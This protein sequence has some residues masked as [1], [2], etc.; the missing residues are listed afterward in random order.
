[1]EIRE[2]FLVLGLE[3]TKDAGQIKKA[4]RARLSVTNPEDDPEGFKRLRAAYE[5]AIAYTEQSDEEPEAEAADE[6]PSGLWVQRAAR[7]YR[8]IRERREVACWEQLLADEI[9]DSLE[10]EEN[11]RYKLLRFLMDHF[12]L[13]GEVWKCLDKKLH[14]VQD[15][16]QLREH[17]PADFINYVVSRCERGEDIDFRQ[18]EGAPDAD[19]DLFLNYYDN[20][21]QALEDENV[22]EAERLLQESEGLAITHPAMEICRGNLYARKGEKERGADFMRALYA[23]YPEDDMVCYHTAEML[24]KAG[25]RDE[26]AEIYCKLKAKSDRHYMAN[27]RLTE[28]YYEQGAYPT[29]KKCAEAVLSVGADDTFMELLT[30]V[31]AMLEQDYLLHW[32]QDHNWREALELC[33]CYLQDGEVC[34]GLRLAEEIRA[35]ITE[36]KEAEYAGLIAKLLVEEAEYEAAIPAAD[37]WEEKLKVKMRREEPDEERARDEDRLR[38]AYMIRMQCYRCLG[39]KDKAYFAKAIAQIEAVETGSAKD[40]GLLL[41]KAQILNEMEEYERS[42]EISGKLLEEYQVYAAAANAMESYKRQWIAAGVIQ[43]ARICIQKYP[44]YVRAY[45]YLAKVFLDLDEKEELQKVFDEAEQNKVT[46]VF[47][48]AYRYQLGYGEVPDVEVLNQKLDAFQNDFQEKVEQG[49][50]AF[51]EP[52]LDLINEYLYWYPG[53]YMLR[54]RASFYKAAGKYELALADYERAFSEEPGNAYVCSSMSHIY[55]LR[56]EREK[57]L[58]QIKRAILYAEEDGEW[59]SMLYAQMARIYMQM[60]EDEQALE[61]FAY[62]EKQEDGGTGHLYNMAECLAR[63]SRGE[64]AAKKLAVY[65]RKSD[66]TFYEGY[67][68]RLAEIWSISGDYERLRQMLDA[69]KRTRKIADGKAGWLKRTMKKGSTARDDIDYFISAG[70]EALRVGD[71]ETALRMLAEQ[72]RLEEI[73]DKMF[74]EGYAD[75]IFVSILYGNRQSAERYIEKLKQWMNRASFQSADPYYERPKSKLMQEFLVSYYTASDEELQEILDR[76]K[77]CINC[78]FC[79]LPRCKE[80]EAM[81]I[82]LLMKQRETERA[83]ERVLDNLAVQPYDEYMQALYVVLFRAEAS[84][85]GNTK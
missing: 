10:E 25:Q 6:T 18:F 56:G 29:A 83:R 26:A 48:D 32:K 38:Q 58:Q 81:R 54:R 53:A 57:A 85:E 71:G 20:C 1:M 2:C 36:E 55:L 17:F 5:G 47:L 31:N 51:Y 68:K 42:L 23:R 22:T 40:I 60:G 13:P 27:V 62:C 52:G 79:L 44:T 63:L 46:S 28:W 70:W 39:Y 59:K 30:K 82:L 41:E 49:E 76:E 64:E 66:D 67:Y 12:R 50:M 84:R 78:D 3:K 8:D 37:I 35:E 14:L 75:V 61:C 65:Y 73:R 11:C 33:W 4:Y 15:A 24:W 19:Y 9:L 77:D 80:L 21:W 72:I 43:N 74:H 69:W 45:E 7:I 16:A 34:R